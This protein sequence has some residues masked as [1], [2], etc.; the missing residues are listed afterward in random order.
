MT[1]RKPPEEHLP[2]G[3]KSTYTEEMGERICRELSNGRTITA[4]CA[5][6][7]AKFPAFAEAYAR[8]RDVQQEVFA[9]QIIDIAATVEDPAKARNMIDARKWH[10]AKVAP[11]KW[12]DRV[13]IDAKVEHNSGPSEGLTLMLAMLEKA[14]VG[15]RH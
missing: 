2:T 5:E 6:E 1:K 13:E 12:G 15:G 3:R 10:A 4:I 9:S 14:G 11:K 8:A 7:W